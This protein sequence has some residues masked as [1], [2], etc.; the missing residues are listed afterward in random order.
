MTLEFICNGYYPKTKEKATYTIEISIEDEYLK[1]FNELLEKGE[2][3]AD[4]YNYTITIALRE[5]SWFKNIVFKEVTAINAKH[6]YTYLVM[7]EWLTEDDNGLDY[8]LY[9]NYNDAKDKYE[10]LVEDEND[11]DISW[12]GSE[13][14]DEN[15]EVNEG[16]EFE[17]SEDTDEEKN[18]CWKVTDTNKN[19]YSII[20]LTKVEIL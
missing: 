20:T 8:Y 15:G 16:F 12:I 4:H 5:L 11:A 2:L 9:K 17:Y 10:R 19:R 18:L 7:L 6:K 3:N 14:F 13:V 1:Y